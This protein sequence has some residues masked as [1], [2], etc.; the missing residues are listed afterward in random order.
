V[1]KNFAIFSL[2]LSMN[3]VP[4][5]AGTADT[6]ETQPCRLTRYT[7][8][9]LNTES[10]GRISI[11]VTVNGRD[12]SFLVDTG[13]AFASINWSRAD[14]LGLSRHP[15][16]KYEIGV[17][18]RYLTT[19]L[20]IDKFSIGLLNG[21]DLD[22]WVEPGSVT[23]FDGILG[24]DM[25][26]YFDLDID[27]AHGKLGIFSPDHCPG[28]V[29]Y[30]TKNGYIAVPMQSDY[31]NGH[32]IRIPVS[33]DGKPWMA[34]VD[35]G[36]TMSLMTMR[37]ANSLGIPKDAPG[38]KLLSSAGPNGKYRYY[39]Y[40]FHTLDFEGVTVLN[41]N[42]RIVS[43]DVM[44]GLGSDIILGVGVLRQLHMYIAY[45]EEKLYITPALAD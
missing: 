13:G 16:G 17:E 26:H 30:W 2:L 45:K 23:E 37:T 29:V 24:P 38:L 41:P 14:E 35:T 27:F 15:T 44:R 31:G 22:L 25:L 21:R 28:K 8:V 7:S 42:I 12:Y 9:P 43:D 34:M 32:H 40:H 19:Y 39:S 36:A 4:A 5:A 6:A 11:P 33:V 3:A 18:G 10:D 20:R 1:R